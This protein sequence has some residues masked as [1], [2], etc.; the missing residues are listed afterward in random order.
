MNFKKILKIAAIGGGLY[1]I[2]NASF[3]FG[4]GYALNYQKKSNLTADEMLD[5][6]C[7]KETD[8]SLGTK[9]NCKLIEFAAREY[10]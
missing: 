8:V 10:N 1:A 6:I 7:D 2:L 5:I 3:Q 4:K 9:I